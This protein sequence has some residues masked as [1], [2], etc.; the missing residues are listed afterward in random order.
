MT[1]TAACRRMKAIRL[2]VGTVRPTKLAVF[3]AGRSSAL[4]AARRFPKGT[5]ELT[6]ATNPIG[7]NVQ[8]THL[9]RSS[10]AQLNAAKRA[11]S[12]IV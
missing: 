12:S 5:G 10:P 3:V 11:I 9:S 7:Q 2:P 4:L 6:Q 8:S 1:C